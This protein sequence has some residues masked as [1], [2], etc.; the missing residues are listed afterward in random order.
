MTFGLSA[1]L[2]NVDDAIQNADEHMYQGKR[3]G[4]NQIIS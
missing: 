4:K 2:D 1:V 3:S